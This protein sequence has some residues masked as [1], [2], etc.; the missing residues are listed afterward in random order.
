[1]ILSSTI[2]NNIHWFLPESNF[3]FF[4]SVIF[5]FRKNCPYFLIYAIGIWIC[6]NTAMQRHLI[7][8]KIVKKLVRTCVLYIDIKPACLMITEKQHDFFF[9]FFMYTYWELRSFLEF[10][11]ITFL[12]FKSLRDQKLA[13]SINLE[14]VFKSKWCTLITLCVKIRGQ[15]I[16]LHT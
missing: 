2:N 16:Y 14:I 1:M 13:H 11:W 6:V 5:K 4:F 3:S 9:F 7:K 12:H 10:F 8:K 15:V